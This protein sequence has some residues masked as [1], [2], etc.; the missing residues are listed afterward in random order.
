MAY[1]DENL[2]NAFNK[3]PLSV[4]RLSIYHS[5]MCFYHLM[6]KRL[7]QYNNESFRTINQILTIN[8]SLSVDILFYGSFG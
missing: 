6:N 2:E 4:P 1:Y 5:L 7:Y 3:N 8:Y